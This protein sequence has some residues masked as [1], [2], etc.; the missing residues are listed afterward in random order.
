M[1]PG[2]ASDDWKTKRICRHRSWPFHVWRASE[3][4]IC[5]TICINSKT[6][7]LTNYNHQKI[8]QDGLM[9]W[10]VFQC[11]TEL[12]PKLISRHDCSKNRR[13]HIKLTVLIYRSAIFF[14]QRKIEYTSVRSIGIRYP[15]AGYPV[16]A[17]NTTLISAAALMHP[18][19]GK[20][21]GS[22][23]N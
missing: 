9:T 3:C 20:A 15:Q 17:D 6:L 23:D 13:N 8:Q 5:Y 7:V 16:Q 19:S 12:L 4:H 18:Q 14:L 11:N 22:D 1:R 10:I 21:S 2:S